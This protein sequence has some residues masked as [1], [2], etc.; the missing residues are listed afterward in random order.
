MDF[1]EAKRKARYGHRDWIAYKT[2]D[3]NDVYAPASAATLKEAMLATGTQKAFLMICANSGHLMK[4][5]W[6]LA[7]NVRRQF[8]LGYR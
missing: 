3:G 2:R 4:M 6:W 1:A 8:V 5:S 7:N